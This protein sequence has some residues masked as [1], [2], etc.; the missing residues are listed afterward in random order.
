VTAHQF[1]T[2]TLADRLYGV[3]VEAV[4]EV[5]RSQR[6]TRVPLAGDAVAGLL[7]LRGEVVTAVDLR[8][9]MEVSEEGRPQDPMNV[10]IRYGDEVVSLLVDRIGDVMNVDDTLFEEPPDTLDG[11]QR[12]L[13]RGAY[14]LD[15]TLLHVLDIATVLD[16]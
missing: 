12:E 13:V 7:S 14:K 9:R 8:R 4:Q 3:E 11:R 10:V 15:G 2:F 16:V 6:C 1:A 5:L